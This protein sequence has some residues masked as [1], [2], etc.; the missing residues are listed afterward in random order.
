MIKALSMKKFALAILLLLPMLV[1]GSTHAQFNPTEA[2]CDQ[3]DATE[4]ASSTICTEGEV[5]DN[6]IVGGDGILVQA[7]NLL[8]I[9]AAVIATII[10]V[11]AGITMT[12]SQGDSQKV[13]DSRNAIIY[14]GVGILVILSSRNLVIYI[15]NRIG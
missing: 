6:P 14:A 13:S 15:I 1:V 8:S 2:S 11:V 9:V 4:R 7:T 3:L 12:L 5:T 10:V